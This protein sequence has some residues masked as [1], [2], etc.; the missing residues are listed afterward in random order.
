MA[1]LLGQAKSLNNNQ[2]FDPDSLE[3]PLADIEVASGE[4]S[5]SS[6]TGHANRAIRANGD[7]QADAN[8]HHPVHT[9]PRDWRFWFWLF[10]LVAVPVYGVSTFLAGLVRRKL[11]TAAHPDLEFLS[12]PVR[13]VILHWLFIITATAG[14]ASALNMIR[15]PEIPCSAPRLLCALLLLAVLGVYLAYVILIRGTLEYG[16]SEH[17]VSITSLERQEDQFIA[18]HPYAALSGLIARSGSHCTPQG[19]VALAVNSTDES[20][21]PNISFAGKGPAVR[22]VL[23]SVTVNWTAASLSKISQMVTDLGK[24]RE[25]EYPNVHLSHSDSIE[26]IV[27]IGF[28]SENEEATSGLGRGSA[29]AW[30]WLFGG[31]FYV[32]S[33]DS[34][35][36]VRQH[37]QKN[38]VVVGHIPGCL[39]IGWDCS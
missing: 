13:I 19:C 30:T 29:K 9:P 10:F 11:A 35:P 1:H 25:S 14:C 36:V 22:L 28:V 34:I 33:V 12:P 38:D 26:G 18:G 21:F 37:I 39:E 8:A 16:A 7:A 4:E 23:Q 3:N 31:V 20:D 2:F 17:F 24:C 27:N 32:Y 15:K 6:R 5:D